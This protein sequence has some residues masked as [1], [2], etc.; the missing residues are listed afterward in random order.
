MLVLGLTGGIATGKSTISKYFTDDYHIPV[1]DADKIA[2]DIVKPHTPCYNE[3]VEYFQPKV[4]DLILPDSY[5]LNRAAL[6]AYVFAHKED[7]RK[8]N[9]ITHP[10]VRRTIY[11]L[12]FTSYINREPIVILDVPLLF[13]SGLNWICSR[14]L[15]INCN[16][17]NQLERLLE[18]NKELTRDQAINRINAQMKMVDKVKLSD[19]VIENDGTLDDLK[20]SL[21]IF[22]KQRLPAHISNK[23]ND[24]FRF[25]INS[26]WNWFQVIFPPFAIFGA[27]LALFRKVIKFL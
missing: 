22:V 27:S 9:S 13:E 24:K 26:W 21:D 11:Y 19:Y 14:T 5:E 8:L 7:L 4:A 20:T 23:D 2:R 17:E 1:I 12:L 15:T 10:V 6:G 3:I 18:R 25:M 16:Y